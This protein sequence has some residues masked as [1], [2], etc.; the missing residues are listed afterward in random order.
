LTS[1]I[2]KKKAGEE[3]KESGTMP[4]SGRLV[5]YAC[6]RLGMLCTAAGFGDETESVLQ[7]FERLILPWAERSRAEHSEWPSE[8]S[9]DNTPI[10]FSVAIAEHG[11]DVRVLFEPQAEQPVIRDY[12]AVGLDFQ[13]RLEREFGANL[14]RYRQIRDLFLP[15]DMH[16]PFAIWS[17]AVFSRGHAPAF[18]AYLNPQAHGAEH[19]P[20]LVREGLERLGFS[21]AWQNL[22]ETVLRRGH[23][24][25]E[26]K[27]FALDLTDDAEARV[28]VYV[29]HHSATAEDLEC[30]SSIAES[31][32]EGEALGFV[33]EMRGSG[34]RL[35]ERAPFTCS[36]F[37]GRKIERPVATTVYVPVCAYARDDAA[38]LERVRG[39]MRRQG[40]DSSLYESIVNGFANRALA[41][42]VGMQSWIALRRF[43]ASARM[44][45]YLATE[46]R[47][48]HAPGSIPAP[49]P[50]RSGSI[51]GLPGASVPPRNTRRPPS[52]VPG[53]AGATLKDLFTRLEQRMSEYKQAPFLR[54][55]RDPNVDA[56]QKLGF[57]PH[58]AHF[59][60]TFGD[61]C[62][63][64]L[65]EH[66]A[67]DFYQELVNANAKEDK[68]HWRW[69]LSDLAEL[70]L[71]STLRYSDAIRAIWG[72]RTRRT[73]KLSYHLCHLGLASDS[74][75]RLMLVHCIEGA[76][77]ATV[78]DL[79]AASRQFTEITGKSLNYL[80]RSH[81]E[82][83]ASHTLENPEIR[84]RLESVELPLDAYRK[85][86]D[87]VDR[88]FQLFA[89]FADE[90]LDLALAP[91]VLKTA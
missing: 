81:S 22:D 51:W 34:E 65:P 24:L 82:S 75:G 77:K 37:V 54:F 60:L 42:G 87:M 47:R 19:A 16:G 8:I 90:M 33:R 2:E 21:A 53:P 55:L 6:A 4:A 10:E 32:V 35:N 1:P 18:K 43:G 49:T 58:V 67:R 36:S 61:L 66:P 69:F 12:R 88:S 62:S 15:A 73:R 59:V 29:R 74:L 86:C 38:V 11:V 84:R 20:E 14:A 27:Y 41:D 17:S 40:F 91:P 45:V 68:E 26:L 85:L 83:E 63:L 79:D 30:A 9:D 52:V 64:V 39:Y 44:T 80:G 50:D 57:A 3:R 46:A 31:Y 13:E 25:D 71:D 5:D 89:D 23:E 76:F 70:D 72:E 48:V 28:K 7:T 56:R 78:L